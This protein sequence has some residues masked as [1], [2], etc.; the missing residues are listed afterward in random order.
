MN[1]E[2][3]KKLLSS[4]PNHVFK[5]KVKSLNK[6][7]SFRS[8]NIAEIKTLAKVAI[9]SEENYIDYQILKMSILS[10]LCLSKDFEYS[11]LT[12]IDFIAICAGLKESNLPEPARMSIICNNEIEKDGKKEQC[13]N[14]IIFDIDFK[15]ILE[16]YEKYEFKNIEFEKVSLINGKKFK[17]I[18][19]DPLMVD[20]LSFKNY[21]DYFDENK[22]EKL[23]E[24]STIAAYINYPIQFIKE[25][26]IDNKKIDN[27]KDESFID[28]IIFFEN[29]IPSDILN[30]DNGLIEFTFKNFNDKR[31]SNLFKSVK[32]NKCKDEKVG[33]FTFDS[34]FTV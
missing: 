34:F 4:S 26:Y 17:F 8:L 30:G 11:K 28:R 3:A 31:L 6:E 2:E 5:F 32:C 16:N 22:D 15:Y 24:K 7:F 19:A 9:S 18:L 13:K 21:I 29:F 14:N 25:L 23:K 12:D 10:E 27:F 33:V 1:L 20:T